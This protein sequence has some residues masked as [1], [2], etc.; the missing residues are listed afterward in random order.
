MPAPWLWR[1]LSEQKPGTVIIDDNGK[2]LRIDK[3]TIGKGELNGLELTSLEGE[4]ICSLLL[5]R[6]DAMLRVECKYNPFATNPC[7]EI[8]V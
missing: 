8:D 6:K 3:I 1:Y 4:E 7:M 5:F 2:R